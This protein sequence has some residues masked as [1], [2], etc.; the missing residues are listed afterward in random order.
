MEKSNGGQGGIR[1][2]DGLAPIPVFET[3]AFNRSA[4]CPRGDGWAEYTDF[5]GECKCAVGA[6]PAASGRVHH[7]EV[8]FAGIAQECQDIA[9]IRV[10]AADFAGGADIAAGAGADEQA[11]G[12]GEGFGFL[13]G[14][15][16]PEVGGPAAGNRAS[17]RLGQDIDTSADALAVR[18]SVCLPG[19]LSL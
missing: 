4:T 6:G 17:G 12:P 7:R 18:A 11:P 9:D 10:P 2:P 13:D 3:G 15:V 5:R 1:T 14:G 8:F 19:Q 16:V